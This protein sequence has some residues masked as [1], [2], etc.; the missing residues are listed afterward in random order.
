M[1]RIYAFQVDDETEAMIEHDRAAV[2]Q[3]MG[4]KTVMTPSQY[5]RLVVRDRI[6]KR[7]LTEDPLDA[8]KFDGYREGLRKGFAVMLKR[9][10]AIMSELTAEAAAMDDAAIDSALEDA[11]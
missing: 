9:C 4:L 5:L 1:P 7:S 6:G 11:G 2:S 8:Y 3:L 10:G